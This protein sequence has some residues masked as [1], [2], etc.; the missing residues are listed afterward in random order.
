VARDG[1]LECVRPRERGFLALRRGCMKI[2][3]FAGWSGSGKTTLIEL[4][5]PRLAGRGLRVSLIKHAHHSFD[6]D[7]PGKDSYRHRHAGCAEVLISSSTRWALMHELRGAPEPTL[8]EL[9]ARVSP[10]DLLLVEGFKRSP[11]PKLEV[12]RRENGKPRLHLDD[13]HIVAIATDQRFDTA[14]PQFGLDD[15]A[16]VAEF[17]ASHGMH[18]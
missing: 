6:V 2:F 11:I 3:G 15:A 4:L 18:S 8:D 7:Q 9:V 16:G 13:P 1:L 5:I 14:L 17:I 12:F 10:C